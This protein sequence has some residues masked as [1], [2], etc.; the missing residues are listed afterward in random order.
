MLL[1]PPCP[2]RFADY[3]LT[4]LAF[5]AKLVMVESNLW[6]RVKQGSLGLCC[7]YLVDFHDSGL[8][9]LVSDPAHHLRL[10]LLLVDLV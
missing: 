10:Y 2:G 3:L 4:I 5:S 6:P 1:I 7:F 8:Y 9:I